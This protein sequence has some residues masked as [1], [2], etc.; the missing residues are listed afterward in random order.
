MRILVTGGIGFIGSHVV[1]DLLGAGHE[2][3]VIDL[4]D[5]QVHGEDHIPQLDP[6]VKFFHGDI[7]DPDCLVQALDGCEAV[8]HLAATVGVGQSMYEVTYYTHANVNGTACLYETLIKN[9]KR[10]PVKKVVVASSMSA[11][12]EGLY[13][14]DGCDCALRGRPR[15]VEQLKARR[16]EPECPNCRKALK[17]MPVPE[18]EPFMCESIYALTK[19][20][21]EEIALMLGKSH[22]IATMALRFFNVYG[23]GQS[24]SN[25]YTGVA[26]IFISRILNRHAPVVYEDGLQSRDFVH[27]RDVARAVRLALESKDGDMVLNVGA[28]RPVTILE[29]AQI[30]LNL[31]GATGPVPCATQ[32]Y[33]FGD[34]RHCFADISRIRKLLGWRPEVSIEDGF[35][36][37]MDWSGTVKAV[38]RFDQA[39]KELE[40][41]GLLNS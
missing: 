29:V 1:G 36:E 18:T 11:Y 14:C 33:R 12:G 2:V 6:R 21:T 41:Y 4:L 32:T 28:N 34:I 7:N 15:P 37:L 8:A 24:L 22:G 40:R 30:I 27:V 9:R 35:R 23:P 38:D 20:D 16:W 25:P 19:R 13:R 5:S 3:R 17:P 39:T 31:S 10:F 26:A